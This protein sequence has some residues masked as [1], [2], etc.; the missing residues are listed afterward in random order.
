VAGAEGNV[1]TATVLGSK[2]GLDVNIA[3]SGAAFTTAAQ[4]ISASATNVS[5]TASTTAMCV[6][7]VASAGNAT[8]TINTAAFVGTLVFEASD[9]GGTTYYTVAA[10]REDGT[11]QDYQ[12]VYT[13]TALYQ[14][15]WIVGLAG[16]T[17]FRVRCSAFTSGTAAIR[18]TPGPF[19]I[20]PNPIA[21]TMPVDGIKATYGAGHI[22]GGGFA[23]ALTG[24]VA[25]WR[26]LGSASKVVKL[27]H[28]DVAVVIGGTAPTGFFPVVLRK[29]SAST[30]GTT[31]T[32]LS[33]GPLD[34][35]DPAATGA[36][37]HYTAAPSGGGVSTAVIRLFRAAIAVGTFSWSWDW[38]GHPAKCPTIR[39][40]GEEIHLAFIQTLGGT[41]PTATWTI[42]AEWTEETP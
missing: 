30:G 12:V 17:H 20:E 22:S 3:G 2:N 32:P 25:V 37:V 27:T 40:T 14:R 39:G 7:A 19:L 38:S 41:S 35:N 13:I 33:S 5:G 8:V 28:L 31:G 21:L 34:T 15:I 9:D 24:G 11:G 6:A 29:A 4:T 16:V 36:P 18:I 23:S 26:L 1:T 42:A 10:G